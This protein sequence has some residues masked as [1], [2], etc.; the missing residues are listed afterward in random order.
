MSG[1][2]RA[3]YRDV[4]REHARRASIPRPRGPKGIDRLA[5][6]SVM[7]ERTVSPSHISCL[8]AER[9]WVGVAGVEHH[10][11]AARPLAM[12]APGC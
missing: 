9:S 1:V 4:A 2:C 11:S 12:L 6:A 10:N 7:A 8:A 3:T 5:A